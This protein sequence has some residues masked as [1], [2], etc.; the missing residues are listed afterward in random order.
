MDD[1]GQNRPY[2]RPYKRMTGVKTPTNDLQGSFT[3]SS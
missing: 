1:W 2:K 3:D